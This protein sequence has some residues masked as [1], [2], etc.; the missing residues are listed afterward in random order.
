MRKTC[1]PGVVVQAYNLSTWEAKED[2]EF[3]ASLGYTVIC[4]LRKTE[5]ERE[6]TKKQRKMCPCRE[7]KAVHL[8]YQFLWKHFLDL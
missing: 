3:Q 4:Y 1:K 8:Q 5:R 2:C 6:R 7:L